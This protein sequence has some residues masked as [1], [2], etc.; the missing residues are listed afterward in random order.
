MDISTEDAGK[1]VDP[2][3]KKGQ[4]EEVHEEVH[5]EV[6]EVEKDYHKAF[7]ALYFITDFP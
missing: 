5:E 1:K 4:V 2:K 7:D 6:K 3:A